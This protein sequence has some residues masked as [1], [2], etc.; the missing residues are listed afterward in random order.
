MSQPALETTSDE[1]PGATG[2][3][4]PQPDDLAPGSLL[5]LQIRRRRPPNAGW[6][7]GGRL[8]ALKSTPRPKTQEPAIRAGAASNQ[9][10]SNPRQD[11]GILGYWQERQSGRD[12]PAWSDLDPEEI[13][14]RWPDSVLLSCDPHRPVPK[15]EASFAEALRSAKRRKAEGLEPTVEYTPLLT[16]WL[17]TIGRA[18]ARLGKPLN[19]SEFFPSFRGRVGY[20]VVGLPLGTAATGVEHVLCHV[21]RT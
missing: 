13:L 19:D 17:L 20:R 6:T 12:F 16:E 2:S 4:G 21:T 8:Q 18:V 15:L 10:R 11:D 5:S 3:P 14:A 7:R 9:V 1:V